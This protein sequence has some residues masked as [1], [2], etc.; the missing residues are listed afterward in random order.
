MLEDT[1]RVNLLYDFY[2]SLLTAKQRECLELYYQYDL[3]LAEIA[4]NIG[5]SRQGVH[6]L[7]K[8]GVKSLEKIEAKLGFAEKFQDQERELK[9]LRKILNKNVLPARE[10]KEALS[11]LDKLLE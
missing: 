2:S 8:R 5:I 9:R 7:L 6:D 3:S 10:R 11:I 4:E 1:M